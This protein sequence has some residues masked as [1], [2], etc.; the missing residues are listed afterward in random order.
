MAPQFFTYQ[1]NLQ[2]P[3]KGLKL[4]LNYW[5]VETNSDSQRELFKLVQENCGNSKTVVKGYFCRKDTKI[6][7]LPGVKLDDSFVKDRNF[8]G[9]RLQSETG[10]LH[11]F[12][13][14]V[15]AGNRLPA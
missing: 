5:K 14:L 9:L 4:L 2:V 8:S 12:D 3:K 13:F 1:A 6:F 15:I 11:N 10:Y 7:L